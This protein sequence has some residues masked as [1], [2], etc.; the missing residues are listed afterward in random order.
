[1]RDSDSGR[2]NRPFK[3]QEIPRCCF[4]GFALAAALS[5][6][7]AGGASH[8]DAS[9]CANE[10]LRAE[11]R[12]LQLPECRAYELAGPAAKNGWTVQVANADGSHM[13]MSTLGSFGNSFK[14]YL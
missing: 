8:A 4:H 1:M 3:R 9:G 5:V 11:S 14:P 6:A 10:V 2:A 12:S 7:L 13:L